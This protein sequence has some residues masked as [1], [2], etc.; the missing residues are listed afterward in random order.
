MA[1][2]SVMASFQWRHHNYVTEKYPQNKVPKFFILG[3][4]TKFLATPVGISIVLTTTPSLYKLITRNWP[5][6]DLNCLNIRFDLF[7]HRCHGHSCGLH[8]KD[9]KEEFF[10]QSSA[11]E[12]YLQD[13]SYL[14]VKCSASE[15]LWRPSLAHSLV[16]TFD[17]WSRLW[18]LWGG[19]GTFCERK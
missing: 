4:E 5:S 11:C 15:P 12:D 13:L 2:K 6:P 16:S 9:K 8:M 3:T 1:K 10:L 7:R 19:A 14:I 18:S 17:H